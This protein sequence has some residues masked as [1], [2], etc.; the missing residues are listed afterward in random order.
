MLGEFGFRVKSILKPESV[1]VIDALFDYGG[2]W[3][4]VAMKF[5]EYKFLT[6]W[7]KL[8]DSTAIPWMKPIPK[9]FEYTEWE[10]TLQ[11]ADRKWIFQVELDVNFAAYTI[12]MIFVLEPLVETIH[13]CEIYTKNMFWKY[14]LVDHKYQIE[15]KSENING[16]QIVNSELSKS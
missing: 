4:S 2:E 5:P 9:K 16:L 8:K 14:K 6:D 11:Y 7:S 1:P 15:S 10:H 12:F 13:H 3:K